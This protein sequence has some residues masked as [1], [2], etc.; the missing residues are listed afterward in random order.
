MAK[1]DVPETFDPNDV[2]RWTS[3][4]RGVRDSEFLTVALPAAPA[5]ATLVLVATMVTARRA[6]GLRTQLLRRST[7]SAGRA[8]YS[9]FRGSLELA[10]PCDPETVEHHVVPEHGLTDFGTVRATADVLA[11]H[12]A[13]RDPTRSAPLVEHVRTIAEELGA[14]VVDHSRRAD[15]GRAALSVDAA[16]RRVQIAFADAGIGIL[17]SLRCHPEHASRL[18]DDADAIQLALERGVTSSSCPSRNMGLGLAIVRELADVLDADLWIA[19]GSALVHRR[20]VGGARAST[21]RSITPWRGTWLGFD[22]PIGG[23]G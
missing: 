21:V 23:P 15:T 11:A 7:T 12:V 3:L 6:S 20:T 16:T 17:A 8:T 2:P 13:R 22:A 19:S 4:A 5:A 14:N 18:S 1:I 10:L 9:R